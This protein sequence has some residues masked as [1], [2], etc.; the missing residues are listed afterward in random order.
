MERHGLK[1][2]DHSTAICHSNNKILQ[3][4]CLPRIPDKTM[5]GLITHVSLI[6]LKKERNFSNQY[7]NNHFFSD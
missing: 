6:Y 2:S 1:V 3:E 7:K 4:I 5:H